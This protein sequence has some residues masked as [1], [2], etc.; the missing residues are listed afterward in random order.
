MVILKFF[1]PKFHEDT[2]LYQIQMEELS[3]VCVG[4]GGKSINR[5]EV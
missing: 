4:E 1:I 3:L 2:T 5:S